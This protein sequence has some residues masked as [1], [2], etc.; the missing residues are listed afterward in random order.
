MDDLLE[1]DIGVASMAEVVA[2]IF[3]GRPE[4]CL[5]VRE[6]QIAKV[7]TW[8]AQKELPQG[9]PELLYALQTM[10]KVGKLQNS[11][12]INY[13]DLEYLFIAKVENLDLTVKKN[14][15]FI[16]THFSK[17]R[18]KICDHLLGEGKKRGKCNTGKFRK[19]TGLWSGGEQK[20][21]LK[22]C[23]NGTAH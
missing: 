8:I 17:T 3:T 13:Y 9:C 7:F 1:V 6:D 14:Q 16:V 21:R 10:A 23:K 2:E 11:L 18:E 22:A 4:L 5:K 15:A 12:V 19:R 20:K